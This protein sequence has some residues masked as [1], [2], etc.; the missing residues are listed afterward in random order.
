MQLKVFVDVF[1]RISL[2]EKFTSETGLNE[3][4]AILVDEDFY[5]D[6]YT[7]L[8]SGFYTAEMEIVSNEDYNPESSDSDAYMQIKGLTPILTKYPVVTHDKCQDE[9]MQIEEER[10]SLKKKVNIYET[11]IKKVL[12]QTAGIT[13][14]VK[15][16]VKCLREAIEKGE[17]ET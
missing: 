4:L 16:N 8:V 3:L 15:V 12:N 9:I 13:D 2:C 5:G 6:R 11:A 17:N 7:E 10:D 1:G 14:L